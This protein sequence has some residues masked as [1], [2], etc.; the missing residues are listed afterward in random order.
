MRMQQMNIMK[1]GSRCEYKIYLPKRRAPVKQIKGSS[2]TVLKSQ[3][4]QSQVFG[5][6]HGISVAPDDV[7]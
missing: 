3:K 4:I 1:V 5:N 2:R 6:T 7:S